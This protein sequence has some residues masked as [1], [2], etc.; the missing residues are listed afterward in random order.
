MNMKPRTALIACVA[1]AVLLTGCF[2]APETVEKEIVVTQIVEKEG[3]SVEKL[4]VVAPAEEAPYPST[5]GETP[6]NDEPYDAVFY[7][8]Y[9]VNPFIDTE[10]DHLSTFAIDVDTGSCPPRRPSAS[11]ST[12]TTLI[13]ATSRRPVEREPLP[14]TWTGRHPALPMRSTTWCA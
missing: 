5:G 1:I 7:K 13:R 10:D 12:S 11:R 8:D 9:G 2:P 3:E 14:S 6:P 4:V